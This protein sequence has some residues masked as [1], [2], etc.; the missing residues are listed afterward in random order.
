MFH[1]EC[2]SSSASVSQ[3]MSCE[4]FTGTTSNAWF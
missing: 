2:L 4:V 1:L 3:C